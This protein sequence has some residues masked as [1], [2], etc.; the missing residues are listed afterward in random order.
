M[1]DE[2]AERSGLGRNELNDGDDGS[3]D[4]DDDGGD[5]LAL[6]GDA[7]LSLRSQWQCRVNTQRHMY[8]RGVGG[9]APSVHLVELLR[10]AELKLTKGMQPFKPQALQKCVAVQQEVREVVQ[11]RRQQA[12]TTKQGR[13]FYSFFF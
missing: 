9:S 10:M 7:L 3:D 4:D 5:G 2:V 8:H 1:I 11:R 13:P 6:D 12:V